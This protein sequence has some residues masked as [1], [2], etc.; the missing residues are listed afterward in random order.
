MPTIEEDLKLSPKLQ[1]LDTE[2]DSLYDLIIIGG[3]PAGLTAGIYAGRARLKTLIVEKAL[4]GGQASLIDKI[5]NYPAFPNGISGGEFSQ[6]LEEHCVNLGVQIIYGGS[7]NFGLEGEIKIVELDN[8]VY[9]ARTV[10]VASGTKAKKLGIPGEEKFRGKGVSYCAVCDGAFYKDKKIMV[11]GGGNTAVE[12]ALFLT[13]YAS[14]ISVVHRRNKLRADK[15]IAERATSSPKIFFIWDSVLEEILGGEKVSEVILRDV[16]TGK[17]T[18][19]KTEGIFIYVGSLPETEFIKDY[20]KLDEN[21]Y[22]ITDEDM[23]TSAPG[24]FAAGDVRHKSLRQIVTAASDGAL[25][26]MS[27]VKYLEENL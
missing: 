23:Q 26:A 6:K 3:G 21:G 2:D 17:K 20:I 8:K 7:L 15:I 19:V 25:A 24:I 27:V 13:R 22:V 14:S 9:K 16:K 5:E 12:E 10:V 11:V 4:L 1:P 18:L